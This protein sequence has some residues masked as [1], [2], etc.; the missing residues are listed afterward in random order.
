MSSLVVTK[1]RGRCGAMLVVISLPSN[2]QGVGGDGGRHA[3]GISGGKAG[4]IIVDG[5]PRVSSLFALRLCDLSRYLAHTLFGREYGRHYA[6]EGY[7][8]A[9][10]LG[11]S[12]G[13]HG[14]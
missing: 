8:L 2:D 9:K 11:T 3:S 13:P 10:D 6:R 7:Q 14:S 1:G 5:K 12:K 4:V